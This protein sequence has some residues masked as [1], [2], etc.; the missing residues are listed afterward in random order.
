VI[1]LVGLDLSITSTGVARL[2]LDA[3]GQTCGSF[4]DVV[5]GGELVADAPWYARAD[6]IRCQARLI[7]GAILPGVRPAQPPDLI[8]VEGSSFGS[9]HPGASELHGLRWRVYVT[10]AA[11]GCQLVEVSPKTLKLYATGNG[12]ASKSLVVQ[13]IR[14]HYGDRFDVPLRRS[15]GL[16][17]VAD[18]VTLVAMAARAIGHPID[19]DHPH[20]ERAM[21][22]PKWPNRE[23]R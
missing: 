13:A 5:T 16:E 12:N 10:L 19:L 1:R 23:D 21:R 9:N 22:S 4:V 15:D 6:R 3:D 18:A 17:D 20:R 14:R 8:A 2:Q 11:A 7:A